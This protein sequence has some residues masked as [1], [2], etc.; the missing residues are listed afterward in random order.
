MT[1]NDYVQQVDRIM[2][3]QNAYVAAFIGI[4][5]I[6]LVVFFVFQWRLSSSKVSEMEKRVEEKI[7]LK[8][9]K[10]ISESVSESEDKIL[11]EAYTS[12][13]VAVISIIGHSVHLEEGKV[14]NTPSEVLNLL[15]SLRE[16]TTLNQKEMKTIFYYINKYLEI[17]LEESNSDFIIEECEVLEEILD[18][19]KVNV[20]ETSGI[21]LVTHSEVTKENIERLVADNSQNKLL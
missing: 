3:L 9:R 16:E 18:I 12:F 7:E 5:S 1:S 19:A 15:L 10:D 13:K 14:V 6:V 20:D 4:L 11:K 8:Y 21:W 17:L 2:N